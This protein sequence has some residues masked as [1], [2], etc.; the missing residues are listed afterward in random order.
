MSEYYNRGETPV[1]FARIQDSATGEII[2][3]EEVDSIS[4]TAYKVASSWGSEVRTPITGHTDVAIP[5]SDILN[6]LVTDDP[7]WTKDATGYNFTFEPDS[8]QTPLFANA[9][10]YVLVVTVH[11]LEANPLPIE[12]EIEV[13]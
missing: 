8:R 10:N 12:F 4:Y 1:L 6:A 9:G 13:Q 7:R 5:A 2:D 3:P 11:F